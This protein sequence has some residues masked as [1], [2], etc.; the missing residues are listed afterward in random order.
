MAYLESNLGKDEK[1]IVKAE[2][3]NIA[4]V[5]NY[6]IGALFFIGGIVSLFGDISG[7]VF[8]GIILIALA[9]AIVLPIML[10]MKNTEL[11]LTNKKIIGK[12]GVVNTKVMD[13]PLNKINTISVE[14]GLGGKILGYGKIVISTSSGGYNFNYI[15]NADSFRSAVME[16]IDIYDEERVRKQ[17]EQMASAMK[18]EKN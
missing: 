2:V 17:A 11:G 1:I 7:L 14:Q 16:Q 6:F 13:S 4:A 15:Y 12:C 9:L 10:S 8:I 18:Q 5:P 3:N